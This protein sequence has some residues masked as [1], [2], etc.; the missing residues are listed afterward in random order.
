[1]PDW[2]QAAVLSHEGHLACWLQPHLVVSGAASLWS[3]DSLLAFALGAHFAIVVSGST[4]D[5]NF[6]IFL[7]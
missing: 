2:P 6:K 4:R 3:A 1:M 5:L 7:R